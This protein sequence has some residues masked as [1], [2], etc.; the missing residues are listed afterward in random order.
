MFR[1]LFILTLTLFFSSSFSQDKGTSKRQEN[2]KQFQQWK[3]AVEKDGASKSKEMRDFYRKYDNQVL[4]GVLLD[5][6]SFGDAEFTAHELSGLISD[7]LDIQDKNT[8]RR[9]RKS[10]LDTIKHIKK[11]KNQDLTGFGLVALELTTKPLWKRNEISDPSS[12][13][14]E[15]DQEVKFHFRQLRELADDKSIQPEVRGKA[16]HYLGQHYS[17]ENV[18]SLKNFLKEDENEMVKNA[19]RGLKGYFSYISE[20]EKSQF[21]DQL[22]S[23]IESKKNNRKLK[24]GKKGD[25]PDDFD[26]DLFEIRPVIGALGMIK[27]PKA[28]KYLIDLNEKTMN[29]EVKNSIRQALSYKA[30]KRKMVYLINDFKKSGSADNPLLPALIK[31][32]YDSFSELTGDTLSSSALGFLRGIQAIREVKSEKEMIWIK[33]Q[34]LSKNKRVRLE[35]VETLH[36]LL[37]YEEQ[38]FI[39]KK[40]RETETDK[41]MRF[42]LSQYIGVK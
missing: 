8:A 1:I 41:K 9:F 11:D 13:S 17:A 29:I 30:D 37:P 10:V 12:L 36:L 16:V 6:S 21:T 40:L 2:Y 42:Q 31:D 35:A 28:Q 20:E 32:N 26:Y 39:F 25:T 24:L 5:V 19:G 27:S 4:L 22:I 7:R 38:V 15:Q 18:L 3:E 34:L 14:A 23:T 33:A